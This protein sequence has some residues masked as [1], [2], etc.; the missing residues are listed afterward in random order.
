MLTRRSFLGFLSALPL[1]GTLLSPTVL[2]ASNSL[3]RA[4]LVHVRWWSARGFRDVG[5]YEVFEASVQYD[6]GDWEIIKQPMGADQIVF[7]AQGVSMDF[8]QPAVEYRVVSDG[9]P[10]EFLVGWGMLDNNQPTF[11]DFEKSPILMA[12]KD[13]VVLV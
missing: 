5:R 11:W 13:R 8:S 10:I 3:R 6:D 9:E 4:K 1:V 7:L 12:T 2:S